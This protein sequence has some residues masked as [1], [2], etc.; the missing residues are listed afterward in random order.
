M[1]DFWRWCPKTW[2]LLAP[3]GA[4]EW[5]VHGN[6]AFIVVSSFCAPSAA[7]LVLMA[8]NDSAWP[9]YL[10]VPILIALLVFWARALFHDKY[11]NRRVGILCAV[12]AFGFSCYVFYT[13]LKIIAF[14]IIMRNHPH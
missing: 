2:R 11:P 4:D 9:L 8:M 5:T 13:S 14:I 1:T 12:V 7:V 3:P 10:M 6:A